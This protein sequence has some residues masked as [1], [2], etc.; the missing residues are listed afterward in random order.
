MQAIWAAIG[1]AP[2]ILLLCV[3]WH[4]E[5]MSGRG[6]RRRTMSSAMHSVSPPSR[7]RWAHATR[8]GPEATASWWCGA[9]RSCL[10]EMDEAQRRRFV[11]AGAVLMVLNGT[12]S[13]AGAVLWMAQ[14]ALCCSCL[15]A[16]SA[17]LVGADCV[18]YYKR[19]SY[20]VIADAGEES[21]R[22]ARTRL[23]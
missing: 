5:R 14:A 21:A 23:M 9:C 16:L 15:V 17:W 20:V 2:L 19:W 3:G 11:V 8:A 7:T 4:Y 6:G 22:R 12:G 18:A 13:L 10:C 1:A